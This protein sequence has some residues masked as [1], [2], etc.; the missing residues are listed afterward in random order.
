M[1]D[2]EQLFIFAGAWTAAALFI[3]YFIPRWP[4]KVAAVALIVGIPFWELPYGYYNFGLQCGELARLRLLERLEPQDSVCIDTLDSLLFANLTRAGF[5]RIELLGGSD[6]PARD[7]ASGKVTSVVKREDLQSRFCLEFRNNVRMPRHLSRSETL[8]VRAKNRSVVAQQYAIYWS[9][10]W[11][12]RMTSP[13]LGRG[14]QC[15][16]D[17]M[18]PILAIR[19]GAT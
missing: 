9:G 17:P 6:D 12:Q 3:A 19:R 4:A 2:T 14:G 15:F 1:S 8:I 11:W 13:I 18:K 5:S 10:L 16:E 7:Q